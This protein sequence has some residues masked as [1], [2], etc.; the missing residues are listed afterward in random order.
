MHPLLTVL[1]TDEMID[2]YIIHEQ[3]AYRPKYTVTNK[4]ERKRPVERKKDNNGF[5]NIENALK[6]VSYTDVYVRERGPVYVS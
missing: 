3:T 2:R 5:K 4:K 1:Q 6:V